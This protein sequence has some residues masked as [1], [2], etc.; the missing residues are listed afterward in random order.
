M[1][2]AKQAWL[3]RL[4]HDKTPGTWGRRRGS[5]VLQLESTLTWGHLAAFAGWF[6]VFYLYHGLG[7]TVGYHRL[8]T[9]K[10]FQVPTWLKYLIVSGGYLCLMGSPI[11]WVGVHRLH[12]QKSDAD[13][14]PH[15][16]KDGFMHALLGWMTHMRD[17]QSDEELQKQAKDL[18]ED[19]L[20]RF[21]GKT[22]DGEQAMLCLFNNILFRVAIYFLLG[23]IALLASLAATP[24]VFLAPQLVNA[25]CHL[26]SQGY[27]LWKTTDESCNVWWVAILSAGEG[28]HNA[29]HAM[30]TCARHGLAW[31]ELDISWC[32]IWTMEKLGLAKKVI[33]PDWTKIRPI[34]EPDGE[35][36]LV[37]T[38]S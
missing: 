21:L 1:L 33:R 34:K 38:S 36:E 3:S 16:P 8:L 15:S 28:W 10:S 4:L 12:H 17:V 23:P 27:R 31:W 35:P 14:D 24:I 18:L 26:P 32:L 29:H 20:F 5:A 25:V 13:G 9:H 37:K 19:P 7:I 11:V 30:P 6:L 22:H 2:H